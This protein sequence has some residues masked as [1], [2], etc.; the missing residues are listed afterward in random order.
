MTS[1]IW[2]INVKLSITQHI[3]TLRNRFQSLRRCLPV[4]PKTRSEKKGDGTSICCIT[5]SKHLTNFPRSSSLSFLI[6]IEFSSADNRGIN[7]NDAESFDSQALCK[8]KFPVPVTL[9][10][11]DFSFTFLS[12]HRHC[13]SFCKNLIIPTRDGKETFFV[14]FR[15]LR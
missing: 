4:T 2:V 8:I 9:R 5:T 7:I 11:H 12:F 13:S 15:V 14:L 1:F 3:C 10:L 6:K